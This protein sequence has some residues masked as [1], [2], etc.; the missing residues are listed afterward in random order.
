MKVS[1]I[2][3]NFNYARFLPECIESALAQTYRNYEVLVVDD[4]S[5]DDSASVIQRYAGRLTAVFKQNGGQASAFHEGLKNATG[6]LVHFLDAD[7]Y[8]KVDCLERVVAVWR[9][10]VVKVQF[11]LSV[12]DEKGV[13]V[14]TRIPSGRMSD[15]HA[16][17]MMHLFGAYCS[18][19][20]SGNV[21]SRE[22]LDQVLP[23]PNE[24]ELVFGADAAAI[25]AAPYFGEI[26]SI[27]ENL[28]FYRRHGAAGSAATL[29]EFDRAG[30][31]QR[32]AKE[33]QWDNARDRC[34][35]LLLARAGKQTPPIRF[36]EPSRA[37]RELCY[38][39]L[40]EGPGDRFSRR[41][42][43]AWSGARGALHWDGYNPLQRMLA[44]GW[45]IGLG[46]LPYRLA[47][48]FI[49]VAV[50]MKSRPGWMSRFLSGPPKVSAVAKPPGN[51]VTRS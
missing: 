42:R 13:S 50:N 24:A 36:R 51:P 7:D 23:I 11:P 25:Y 8:L 43:A 22:L 33:H 18:P 37:K 20:S 10:G 39:R 41:L 12:V 15:R 31:L 5:T 35:K 29:A 49:K 19:P 3:N 4:G 44:A 38:L 9:P 2:I 17:K 30:A 40:N 48:D 46:F 45:F 34:M 6:D 1:L 28:G 27:N 26:V 21:F 32:L 47:E 14:H 16:L